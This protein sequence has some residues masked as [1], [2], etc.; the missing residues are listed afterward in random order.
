[1]SKGTRMKGVRIPPALMQEI[2][3]TIERRNTWTRR[4]PWKFT[5]FILQAIRDKI[6]QMKRSR[7][8]G[9]GRPLKLT[10]EEWTE[11]YE[12]NWASEMQAREAHQS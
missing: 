9:K 8:R 11:M 4:E 7:K 3:E 1:M 6:D 10:Y 2:N 12:Q 5:G